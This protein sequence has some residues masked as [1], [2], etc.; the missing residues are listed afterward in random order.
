MLLFLFLFFFSLL[1]TIDLI[2]G[3]PGKCFG[4]ARFTITFHDPRQTEDL[5]VAGQFLAVCY[6]IPSA[7]I[8]LSDDVQLFVLLLF[9]LDV[10][11]RVGSYHAREAR[12]CCAVFPA[13]DPLQSLPLIDAFS[14][15]CLLLCVRWPW[16]WAE[17]RQASCF[18]CRSTEPFEC[19]FSLVNI[20]EFLYAFWD[21]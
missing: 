21:I 6:L 14:C 1:M 15:L 18:L 11:A 10:F 13:F 20:F 9:Y 16:C 4:M 5:R 19:I 3:C 2:L 12:Y 7:D 17:T 8:V